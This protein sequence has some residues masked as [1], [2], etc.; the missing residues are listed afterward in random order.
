MPNMDVQFSGQTLVLPGAYYA[1]NVSGTANTATA[2]VPPTILIG[3]CFGLPKNVPTTFATQQDATAAVRG[4]PLGAFLPFVY[5]PSPELNGASIVTIIN[6]G[7]NTASSLSLVDGT[8]ATV[9]TMPS[10]NYGATE[11]LKQAQVSAGSVGGVRLTLFDGYANT[12][13][14]QDNLGLPMQITYDGTASTA[15]YAIT[16]S[17]IS[18]TSTV[19]GESLSI[20]IAPG[21]YDT[22]SKIVEYIN[23]SGAFSA[24]TISNGDLPASALDLPAGSVTMNVNQP[25]NVTATLGDIVFWLSQYA[26]AYVGTPVIPAGIVSSPTTAPVPIPLTHFTG[27]TNVPPT[28]SD[29]AAGFNVALNIP[30]FGVFADS[31]DPAVQAM[32]AQHAKDASAPAARRPRRFFTGSSLGDSVSQA[33]SQASAL[34]VYQATFCYPGIYRT[35]TATGQNTLYSGLYHAAAT[36]GMVAGN[37]VATALTNKTLI[38]TGVEVALT[39]SQID[40]LQAGGVQCLYVPDSTGVPTISSDMTTWL[41]DA[42][43]E[44]VFNQQ[45]GIRQYLAYVLMQALQP[46]T[47]AIQSTIGIANMRKAAVAALNGQIINAQATTGVLNSWDPTSLKLIFNGAQQATTVSVNVVTVGQNRFTLITTYLQPLNISA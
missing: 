30:G 42:N 33:L 15:T 45:V 24:T 18:L 4:G 5:S 22:V 41:S 14:T 44:N 46:Y 40:Q 13:L 2:L 11:N 37:P 20:P 9:L 16:S 28:V 3:Y 21:T 38:G 36:V 8:G 43:V 47:G 26:G 35:N 31:N 27:G 1:D 34:D 23:G 6:V 7:T 29:Y 12:Q 17:A 19:A 32:G 39:V 25:I 10:A